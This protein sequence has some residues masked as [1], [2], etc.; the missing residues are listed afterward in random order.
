[1]YRGEAAASVTATNILTPNGDGK[2]DTW[3]IQDI[4][5]YPK[6]SVRIFD[7]AGRVVYTKNGYT[8]DWEGT[9]RGAP[10]VEGTYYYTVDLGPGL[11]KFNGFI[12][13]L[14]SK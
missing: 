7:R 1:V 3:A 11:P 6:N 4:Q 13:L 5:L 14:R 2:N 8:N 10:L 9:L 12:T